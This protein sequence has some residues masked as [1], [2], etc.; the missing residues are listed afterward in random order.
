MNAA[1]TIYC[2]LIRNA[3]ERVFRG[4]ILGR[5]TTLLMANRGPLDMLLSRVAAGTDGHRA[6]LALA[7]LAKQLLAQSDKDNPRHV[8]EAD[9]FSLRAVE[10]APKVGEAWA[11]RAEILQRSGAVSNALAAWDR[12]TMYEPANA[13]YWRSQGLLLAEAAPN[14]LEDALQAL[15]KALE[16]TEAHTSTAMPPCEQL[17][18]DRAGILRRLNRPKSG[19]SAGACISCTRLLAPL[20]S[21]T[22][23]PLGAT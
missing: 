10:I 5:F 1:R 20:A 4:G 12:A 8:G 18:Q 21:R 9:F 7:R 2:C 6:G 11:A 23:H 3:I 14:R 15:S 16:L 19:K 17:L 13:R 22:E